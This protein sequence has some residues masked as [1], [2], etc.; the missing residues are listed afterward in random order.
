MN[1]LYS[2]VIAF[3]M[4][5]KI[6]M[7]TVEWTKERMRYVFC[8]FPLIGAVTGGLMIL[9]TRV[10]LRITGNENLNT[11]ILM[12][13]PVAV[14]GGIHLDGFLDT[15]DAINSYKT[16][17]EKLAILKDSHSGA[18]A[19]I[20]GLCYFV[21]S[22]GAYSA[23]T[24]DTMM[25]LAEGFVLSRALSGL[26]VVTF[27]MAKKSGLAASFSDMAQKR[28]VGCVMILYVILCFLLM[29]MADPVLGLICFL[30]AVLVF[31]FY[32]KMSYQKFGGITGDLAGFFL[33]VCELVMVLAVVIASN[34]L[35]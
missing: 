21:L 19:I 3:S 35:R 28:V 33:Q 2:M 8:F 13:I 9:W 17:D 32:R 15:S 7:P 16:M 31:I 11:A 12:L 29:I 23:V 14:T 34:L 24:S 5:S 6:P 25:V 30:A 1:I 22:F 26:A 4:Y 20:M 10:G 18:F 27:K